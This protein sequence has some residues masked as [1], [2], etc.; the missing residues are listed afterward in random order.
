MKKETYYWT[1]PY[2][3]A[4]LDPG[5][6]CDCR[7]E[8]A[9]NYKSVQEGGESKMFK[10]D[11]KNQ[12]FVCLDDIVGYPVEMNTVIYN[13]TK[14]TVAYRIDLLYNTIKEAFGIE[15]TSAQLT[16]LT[17]YQSHQLEEFK[18]ELQDIIYTA[19]R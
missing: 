13:P 11:L 5:E 6:T 19:R 18:K 9:D 10:N 15:L 4:N 1:C 2:C 14:D 8:P 7:K 16:H 12:T 3:K 17:L